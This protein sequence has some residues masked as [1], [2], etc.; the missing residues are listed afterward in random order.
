VV[1]LTVVVGTLVPVVGPPVVGPVITGPTLGSVLA[2]SLTTSVEPGLVV[3]SVLSEALPPQA[4]NSKKMS[5]RRIVK[6]GLQGQAYHADISRVA[7]R[8]RPS[9]P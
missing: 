2:P 9:W 5:A 4:A 6:A 1:A 7:A 3:P 8:M